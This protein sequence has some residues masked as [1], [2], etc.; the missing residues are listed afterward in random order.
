LQKTIV[1][2]RQSEIGVIDLVRLLRRRDFDQG[3]WP[4]W[5]PTEPQQVASRIRV[6]V[7]RP[8][9][10]V[11]GALLRCTRSTHSFFGT[12]KSNMAMSRGISVGHMGQIS[13]AD[14][15]LRA[16]WRQSSWNNFQ[17]SLR[18]PLRYRAFC[19]LRY[20]TI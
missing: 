4:P 13:A 14:R 7:Q 2:E 8:R 10:S 20:A 3:A 15:A 5:Q 18:S 6:L 17:S 1:V 12:G 11:A 16:R 9:T 19:A